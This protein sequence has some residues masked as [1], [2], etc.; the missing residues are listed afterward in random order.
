[1]A[2]L[3]LCQKQGFCHGRTGRSSPWVPPLVKASLPRSRF[4]LCATAP[5]THVFHY[6]G[7]KPL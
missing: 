6:R 3:Y 4:V 5:A 7:Q 2:G 1:M